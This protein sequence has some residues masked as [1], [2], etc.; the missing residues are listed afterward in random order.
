MSFITNEYY[1][2]E[3]G[4]IIELPGFKLEGDIVFAEDWQKYIEDRGLVDLLDVEEL[5]NRRWYRL[6]NI[7]FQ[8]AVEKVKDRPI[9]VPFAFAIREEDEEKPGK[10]QL[11][12]VALNSVEEPQL[13]YDALVTALFCGGRPLFRKGWYDSLISML[14]ND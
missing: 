1:N 14:D 2:D 5:Q 10:Y 4:E 7:Y 13:Q 8:K 12:N 11:E 6:I 9:A 3:D